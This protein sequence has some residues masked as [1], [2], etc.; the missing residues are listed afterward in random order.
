MQQGQHSSFWSS[1]LPPFVR[2]SPP[3]PS[4]RHRSGDRAGEGAER[5]P[6]IAYAPQGRNGRKTK[7]AEALKWGVTPHR[8]ALGFVVLRQGEDLHPYGAGLGL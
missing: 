4:V 6:F 5:A 1:V 7:K 8:V 2:K 3:Q